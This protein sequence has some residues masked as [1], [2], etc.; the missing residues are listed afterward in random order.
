MDGRGGR[1]QALVMAGA[2]NDDG[3]Q[4][5]RTVHAV[6]PHHLVYLRLEREAAK[7]QQSSKEMLSHD[8]ISAGKLI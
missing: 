4:V 7:E 3:V 6:A 5:I 1:L 8:S 2:G